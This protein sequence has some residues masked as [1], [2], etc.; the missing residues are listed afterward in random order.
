MQALQTEAGEELHTPVKFI[1]EGYK[2]KVT[3]AKSMKCDPTVCGASV[4]N[5]LHSGWWWGPRSGA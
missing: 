3:G 5:D 4:Y 2:V 1:Y